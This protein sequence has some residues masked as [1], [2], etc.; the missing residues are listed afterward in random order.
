MRLKGTCT[1]K[2][3]PR[4]KSRGSRETKGL[5]RLSCTAAAAV[6]LMFDGE[7]DA[8]PMD[9][10]PAP[11]NSVAAGGKEMAAYSDPTP[12]EPGPPPMVAASPGSIVEST[13]LV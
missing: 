11:K 6:V 12:G 13:V 3:A 8:I 4:V 5:A 10:P 9:T 2:L 1:A 7:R